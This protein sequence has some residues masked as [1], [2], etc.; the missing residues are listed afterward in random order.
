MH[1]STDSDALAGFLHGTTSLQ[2]FSVCITAI[3]AHTK[4]LR[5]PASRNGRCFE[6]TDRC[7]YNPLVMAKI[8]VQRT[9]IKLEGITHQPPTQTPFPLNLDFEDRNATNSKN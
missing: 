4:G 7:L 1:Y 3:L 2:I 9:I 5:M 8:A 6:D